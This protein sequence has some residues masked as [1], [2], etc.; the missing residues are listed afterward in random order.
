MEKVYNVTYIIKLIRGLWDGEV[1]VVEI[2][3]GIFGILMFDVLLASY[4]KK[5]IIM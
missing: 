3:P 1:S 5:H 2:L 4:N